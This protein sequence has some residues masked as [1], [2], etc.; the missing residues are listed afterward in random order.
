MQLLALVH[1]TILKKLNIYKMKTTKIINTIAIICFIQLSFKVHAQGLCGQQTVRENYMKKHPE[2]LKNSIQTNNQVAITDKLNNNQNLTAAPLYTIPVVF[3]ILHIGGTENISDAQIQS[4]M[5]I[6]N[7]DYQKLNADTTAVVPTFTNNIA[8]VGVAFKLA[9]KDPNGNCTN[10]IIRHYDV[11]TNWDSD[12]FSLFAYTWPRDRYLNIYIVKKIIGMDGA[13]AFL[14]GDPIP[15]SADVIVC[16]HNYVGNTGTTGGVDYRVLTH[17][18]GHFFSLEHVWGVTN[19]PG[20]ACGDDNVSDTP[21]TKGFTSCA[22]NNAAVCTPNVQENVQ[23]YMDY[24]PCK[25]MFTNGQKAKMLSCLTST[26]NNRQNLYS[27]SNLAFTGVTTSTTNCI[28]LV[29]TSAASKTICVGKSTVV[30][31]Y[32]SNANPTSYQWSATNGAIL[33]S[34]AAANTSVTLINPGPSTLVCVASNANGS[35]SSSIVVNANSSTALSLNTYTESF[36]QTSI[37]ANW[38]VQNITPSP[39]QWTLTNLSSS[40]GNQSMYVN[41]ENA[42]TGSLFI[43][44]TPSYDFLNSPGAS[45]TFKY[46]YAR[47]TATHNDIFKVQASKDC[48]GTWTDIYVPT[49]SSFAAASAGINSNPFVPTSSQ[50]VLYDVTQHP[51]FLN[52]LS[53]NNVKIRF[54]F[55]ED[56][57]NAYGN[58][59]YVDEINYNSMVGLKKYSNISDVKIY[60]NPANNFVAIELNEAKEKT[61]EVFDITGRIIISEQ[62]A[63]TKK[64]INISQLDEGVYYVRV[65]CNSLQ[66]ISKLIKE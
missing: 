61:I 17:E 14:P 32:T 37:P 60:P 52:F 45:F 2:L 40:H 19:S 57:V 20:V 1:A 51:N 30:N 63:D 6:L 13:Y 10:G 29:E 34:P 33:S 65:S 7:R 26:I 53:E 64:Q 24:A 48:G 62:T 18:V 5:M 27:A 66:H 12:N 39:A 58:R 56:S 59:L 49:M 43:L 47:Q 36:E 44:E 28:P 11:N 8:N 46:A 38:Q 22:I 41:A 3:H 50:W 54:Y 9:T 42:T 4:Q 23:N 16:M 25:L 55:K 21:I 31:S 35:N 15:P